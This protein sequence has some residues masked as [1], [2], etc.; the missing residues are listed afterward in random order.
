ME[1][2]ERVRKEIAR[3]QMV[4]PGQLV[5]VGVSGG[6][7]SVALLHIFRC[8]AGELKISLHAAHLNHMFRG[9][10]ARAD[11]SFVGEL[12]SRWGI[13]CTVEERN[14]PAHARENRLSA[15]VAARDI[16]YRF[17]Y[18]VLKRT[19]GN[20]IALAHHADD[21]AESVLMN[22]L[23]GTGLRG[24]S[25]I[26]PVRDHLFIR[27]LLNLRRQEI[28][29]YCREQDIP[30]RT[31]SSNMKM[32]YRR[33]K[34]R[35]Q[36]IPLLER[37]YS[38]GLVPVLNRLAAQAR[39]DE[40]F[41]EEQ[42]QQAYQQVVLSQASSSLVLDRR[43][44]AELPVALVRRVLR[45]AWENMRGSKQDLGFEHIEHLLER[46]KGGGPERIWELPGGLKARLSHH[47][48]SFLAR[49]PEPSVFS[50]TGELPVPG[51]FVTSADLKIT[52]RVMGREEFPANPGELPANQV[53]LDY[54]KVKLPLAVRF[55]QAG[56]VL[57][58]FGLGGK[59]KLKK[60]L[61]DRKIPRHLRDKIPLVVEQKTGK[62][63]WVAGIR[64]A[65]DIGIDDTT[66]K[67]ILLTLENGN[68][69]NT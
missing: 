13:P 56:D 21:Q 29:L 51:S 3:Y 5:I 59:V 1:V 65:A 6:P 54:A 50:K 64:L 17:F 47:T 22:L 30:F 67:V 61:I 19:A 39:A 27:P 48:L 14:V 26:P 52:S 32:L 68:D 36:L 66:E 41:M 23:R 42:A 28:E 2:L 53:V 45:I 55:R 35:H 18:D 43:V 31:D 7:D 15:Q 24:L 12:C 16:R 63:V 9:E 10:E 4:E 44:L 20:K 69:S 60:L 33:N 34:L 58:P 46:L 62:I 25:G 40:E 8:L 37:E 57:V 49:Q 38:P 11:A